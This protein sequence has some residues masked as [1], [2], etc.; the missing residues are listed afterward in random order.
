VNWFLQ[1][2]AFLFVDVFGVFIPEL[3]I[4]LREDSNVSLVIEVPTNFA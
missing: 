1:L 4:D 3:Q 2:D